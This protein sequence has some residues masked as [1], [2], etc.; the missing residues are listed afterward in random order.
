[1]KRV[2]VAGASLGSQRRWDVTHW[3]SHVLVTERPRRGVSQRAPSWES[4]N[5]DRSN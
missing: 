5:A 3:V 1:M 4:A 2:L